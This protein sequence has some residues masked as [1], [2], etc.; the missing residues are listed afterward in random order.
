MNL[1]HFS[2]KQARAPRNRLAQLWVATAFVLLAQFACAADAA[3]RRTAL[4]TPAALSARNTTNVA[5]KSYDYDPEDRLIAVN[6]GQVRMAYDGDG[7]RVS[8]TVLTPGGGSKTTYYLVDDLNPTGH[9]Q[10]LEEWEA[11]GTESPGL[12]RSYTH[13]L[14]LI[15]VRDSSDGQS[16]PTTHYYGYDGHGSVRFLTGEASPAVT[17]TYTYDAYGVL[18]DQTPAATNAQTRNRYLYAGEQWD[19]EVGLYYNRARYLDPNLGRFWTMDTFEGNPSDPLSLHK[20]LYADGNPVN[21]IDPSGLMSLGDISTAVFVYVSNLS[22][23][24]PTASLAV[25][26]AASLGTVGLFTYDQE[27]RDA[28]LAAGPLGA[29]QVLASEAGELFAFG[30]R[31]TRVGFRYVTGFIESQTAILPHVEEILSPAIQRIKSLY[32]EAEI[33][34]R[35]S[36]ARGA[37]F[38]KA[39]RGL[40]PFESESFDVDAYVVCDR[41]AEKIG[42]RPS[43]WRQA[44]EFVS[45]EEHVQRG[46]EKKFPGIKAKADET[47]HPF[48]FKIFTRDEFQKK[49]TDAF[50][51]F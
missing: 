14:D 27:F 44:P 30:Y 26:G 5:E 18:L 17:D 34:I 41:L 38:D 10:V 4:A 51:S 33:G 24:F 3:D 9:A 42:G 47:G 40:K 37:S 48:A 16:K 23:R 6:G 49:R 45:L 31:G 12:V 46:L 13:G 21:R 50:N 32:P 22:F 20:Y 39:T 29:G 15:S 7:H 28:L 11:S 35:G 25:R 1:R 36:M 43:S 2:G 19:S 8:K